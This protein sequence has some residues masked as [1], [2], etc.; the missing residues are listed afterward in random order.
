M[1]DSREPPSE[2]VRSLDFTINAIA[3]RK[4]L[5]QPMQSNGKGRVLKYHVEEKYW[6][7]AKQFLLHFGNSKGRTFSFTPGTITQG[8]ALADKSKDSYEMHYRA[9]RYFCCLI[10]I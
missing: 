9:M 1:Q 4:R 5:T 8:L 10:G 7:P 2:P 6:L 3:R